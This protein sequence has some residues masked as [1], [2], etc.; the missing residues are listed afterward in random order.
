MSMVEAKMSV[1][2]QCDLATIETAVESFL[3]EQLRT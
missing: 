2:A 3:A 1:P